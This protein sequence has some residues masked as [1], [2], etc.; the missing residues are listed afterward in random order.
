MGNR[1]SEFEVNDETFTTPTDSLKNV[2]FPT[3]IILLSL[4]GPLLMSVQR[5]SRRLLASA[6]QVVKEGVFQA[7]FSGCRKVMPHTH[8]HS[9]PCS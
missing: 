8:T 7:G 9:L 2:N 5:R 4:E 1:K 6:A 3:K